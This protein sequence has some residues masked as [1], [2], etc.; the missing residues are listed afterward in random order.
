MSEEEQA[1]IISLKLHGQ[2]SEPAEADVIAN[3]EDRLYE[4]VSEAG[5][6]DGNEI[7]GGLYRLYFY[8]P[9]ADR[10]ADLVIPVLATLQI[11]AGSY[12]M[13]RYGGHGATEVRVPLLQE[14]RG[15]GC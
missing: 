2:S 11:E 15:K 13:K 10:L 12:A 7:G 6:Y 14:C 4:A 1:L 3:V 5:Q 9:S 8:G